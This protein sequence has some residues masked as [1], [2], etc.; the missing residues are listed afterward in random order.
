M[1][2]K[3]PDTRSIEEK[4]CEKFADEERLRGIW[5]FMTPLAAILAVISVGILIFL[6]CAKEHHGIGTF[7]AAGWYLGPPAWFYYENEW[8]IDAVDATDKKYRYTKFKLSQDAAKMC[9]FGVA[10]LITYLARFPN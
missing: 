8:L 10:A 7:I 6:P 5:G 3:E 4:K 1:S 9:W 2:D